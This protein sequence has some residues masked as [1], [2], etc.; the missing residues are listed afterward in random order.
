[1]LHSGSKVM[2]YIVYD[3]TTS[4][5]FAKYLMRHDYFRWRE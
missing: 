5:E 2:L 4:D 1:L 3:N